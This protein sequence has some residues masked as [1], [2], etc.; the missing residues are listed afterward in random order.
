MIGVLGGYGAVGAQAARLLHAWGAGPLRIGG[1]NLEAAQGVAAGAQAVAVDLDRDESLTA[2]VQGCTVVVNCAGPSHRSA[3]RVARAALAAGAHHVD[4][5]GGEALVDAGERT[6]LF[7]AGALPGLSG[8]LPRWLASSDFET[9]HTLTAYAGVLDRFT[10]TG[11]EDFLAGVLDEANEP[12]AAWQDGARVSGALTR[13]TARRLPFFPREVAAFPYLDAEG[14]RLAKDLSLMH[15]RWYTALDGRHLGAA[16]DAARALGRAEAV[17]G[18]CRATALDLAGRT[19]YVTLLV[20]LDGTACGRALTRTAVLLAPGIADLTGAV[21]AVATLA[22][23][24]GEVP[25]GAHLA[26]AALD[27]TTALSLLRTTPGLC[28]P[29]VFDLTLDEL[30]TEEE[31]A[32]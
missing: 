6:A 23:L 19:P 7:A 28:E 30:M 3:E 4:A 11:A 17:A 16:L 24:R 31:G 1:R 25:P 32:L 20:Q 9:V 22:V 8:L 12:L 26:A 15:G 13:Q 5:G 14:E 29:M 10:A 2:F 18:L 21:T 27:P